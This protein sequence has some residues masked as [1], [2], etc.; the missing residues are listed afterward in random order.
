M[1]LAIAAVLLCAIVVGLAYGQSRDSP[2]SSFVTAP[3]ER[4]SIS[5]VVRSTGTVE[6]VVTVDVSSEVSGRMADVFVDFNDE[7]KAG[8][9]IARLDQEIFVARI[10]EANADLKIAQAAAQQQEAALQRARVMAENAR[11]A[12]SIAAAELA[13]AQIRQDEAEREFERKLALSRAAA[14][15][16]REF[17]QS[18]TARDAGSAGLRAQQAQMTAK[19]E[20]IEVADAEVLMAEASVHSGQAVVEQKQALLAQA[21][22]NL[23]RTEI[24]AP[25]DGVVIKCAVNQGQTV[26]VSFEA[27]TLFTIAKDLRNMEVHGK[28]DEADVGRLKLGQTAKFT[29]DAHPDRTFTG[30]VRQIR[31]APE[32]VQ[33]V[34]SY[35]AVV[36]ASNAELLLLPGMTATLRIVV[37]DT[38]DTLKIPN[39]ALRFRPAAGANAGRAEASPASTTDGAATVWVA[40]ADG[41]PVPVMVTLGASDEGSTQVTGGPLAEGQRLIVGVANS[42]RRVGLFGIRLGF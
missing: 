30:R 20:A 3:V 33:N 11:T 4:G 2:R 10:N 32:V 1:R 22:A 31:K 6:A 27:K 17:T 23:Q 40:G 41:Q 36:S 39:Q 7:V 8:E 37:D 13:A 25:I 5:T 38:G 28:I 16:E 29:V 18:R 14:V 42:Q 21:E 34:V 35:T 12:R 26:A 15:S 19:A 9:V 24:R